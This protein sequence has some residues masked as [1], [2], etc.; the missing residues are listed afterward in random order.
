MDF[1]ID[2]HLNCWK[3]SCFEGRY[4][5]VSEQAHLLAR[6]PF[7]ILNLVESFKGFVGNNGLLGEA[8]EYS[9]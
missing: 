7:K 5:K 9:D 8:A 3:D 4:L 1:A 2:L 6:H